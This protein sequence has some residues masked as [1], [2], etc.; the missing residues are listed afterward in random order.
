MK[1][2][3]W[4][5]FG[6][7][8]VVD[9]SFW[10]PSAAAEEVV[11]SICA[12]VDD[13]VILESDV[14]YG[15]SSLLL[16]NGIRYPTP[17]QLQS[18]RRQVLEAYITQKILLAKAIEDTVTVEDRTV[19]RELERRFKMLV[20]QVGS[21]DGLAQY[22]GRPVRQLRREM[23]QGVR[24]GLLVETLKQQ[25][26]ASVF[27]R[28]GE[29]VEYYRTHLDSLPT[30]PEKVSLAH[31]LLRVKPSPEARKSAKR[32]ID[33]AFQMLAAGADF[34]SVAR[35][36][37][38]DASASD[39]GR[40]GWTARGEL[41]PEYEEVAYSMSP[42]EISPVVESRYGF[43]IIKL[44]DRQGERIFTQHILAKLEPT[45]QDRERVLLQA[46]NLYGRLVDGEDFAELAAQFSDDPETA[47][48][49]GKLDL[50]TSEDLSPDIREVVDDLEVGQV[51]KPFE[52]PSGVHILK[53]NDRIP[54]RK[55]NLAEDWQVLEQA[56]LADKQE[57]LFR[58]W[59][60]DLRTEHYVW[61]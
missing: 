59:V 52:S 5:A 60:Q 20:Q 61:P 35:L 46:E 31:I 48:K 43:H 45:N 6:L 58:K 56:A 16:E 23:R 44:I 14:S 10:A 32:R 8:V 42:G 36:R 18:F 29:V 21:E 30:V 34:D 4:F 19:E 33:E 15:V 11:D 53:L 47:P 57:R 22:F 38:E 27:V 39:G 2:Y 51:S 7:V 9:V 55:L 50:V 3:P 26:L 25:R 17:E 1:F 49:G 54:A 24:D 40:L 41:V 28:R 37:S 13:E 12:I